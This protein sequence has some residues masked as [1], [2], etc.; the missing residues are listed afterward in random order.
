MDH[1]Y[2]ETHDEHGHEDHGS[3]Q[4]FFV[5]IALCVLTGASFFT[6]TDLWWFKGDAMATRTFMMAV[7][8]MKALLVIMFFMHLI[9]EANWKYVL[10]IPAA[11]MS[12][13]LVL[14]LIPDVGCRAR[15][16][17][18]ERM[19]HAAEPMEE[20]HEEEHHDEPGDHKKDGHEK[21]G[22]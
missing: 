11:M 21:A 6:Y 8:C 9:W 4:Y 15:G 12:V 5:F 16:Y 3:S 18:E 20:H 10:T 22:H 7:S 13:F 2:N 19:Q 14:M 1:D 17:A